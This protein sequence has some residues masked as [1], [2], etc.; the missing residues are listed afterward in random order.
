VY[1]SGLVE[2]LVVLER[3]VPGKKDGRFGV[4][5]VVVSLSSIVTIID[6]VGWSFGSSFT[7]MSPM[8]MHFSN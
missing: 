8:F 3:P 4:G 7:H 1:V 5:I 2:E 6:M